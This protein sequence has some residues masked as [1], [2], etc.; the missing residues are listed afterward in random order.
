MGTLCPKWPNY[1]GVAILKYS[2]PSVSSPENQYGFGVNSN[3]FQELSIGV[4]V[5]CCCA[6]YGHTTWTIARV[7]L[8]SLDTMRTTRS[9]CAQLVQWWTGSCAFVSCMIYSDEKM[10]VYDSF[11]IWSWPKRQNVQSWSIVS[12]DHCRRGSREKPCHDSSIRNRYLTRS[13][14][15]MGKFSIWLV[16]SICLAERSCLQSYCKEQNESLDGHCTR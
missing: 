10:V 11:V 12:D 7:N 9:W 14:L 8:V 16:V 5:D 6:L 15:E 2:W 3:R 13:N 4:E 1:S